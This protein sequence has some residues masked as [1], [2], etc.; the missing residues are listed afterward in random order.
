[1]CV[2]LNINSPGL[3]ERRRYYGFGQRGGG[4]YR[5]WKKRRGG[6]IF[7]QRGGGCGRL[8]EKNFYGWDKSFE[9]RVDEDVFLMNMNNSY[10]RNQTFCNSFSEQ[11]F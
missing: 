10:F 4:G 9:E 3:R 1:M 8:I 7:K 6:F 11:L 5:G 2:S